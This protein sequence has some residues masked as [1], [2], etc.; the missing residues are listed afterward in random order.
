MKNIIRISAFSMGL[1][2]VSCTGEADNTEV[3]VVPAQTEKTNTIVVEK[4]PEKK[5][6]TIVLDKKGVK[7]ETEKIDVEVNK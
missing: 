7:V 6:T 1:I 4:V 5:S 2:L 3:I